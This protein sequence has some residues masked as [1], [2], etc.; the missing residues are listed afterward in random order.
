MIQARSKKQIYKP[1]QREVYIRNSRSFN[2]DVHEDRHQRFYTKY[3]IY[4]RRLKLLLPQY[5]YLLMVGLAIIIFFFLIN[6]SLL[7]NKQDDKSQNSLSGS[8]SGVSLSP[9]PTITLIPIPTSGVTASLTP[10][11]TLVP[12]VTISSTTIVPT[13]VVSNTGILS[14]ISNIDKHVFFPV[15]KTTAIDSNFIPEN[16]TN[17]ASNGIP[18]SSGGFMIK[19]IVV[20]DLKDL[21]NAASSQGINLRV[22][23]AYRSYNEQ[24]NTFNYWVDS[25]LQRGKTQAEAEASAN[26]YSAKAGFSEH[27]LGTTMDINS[28][29]ESNASSLDYTAANT[30]AWDWLES[31][32]EKYGFVLSYP[33][34]KED[35]TGYVYEPWHIRWVGKDVAKELVN[36]DYKNPSNSVTST[37]YFREIWEKV[38]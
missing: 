37:G 19:S 17:L 3:R 21:F 32:L 18:V 9:T 10:T 8:I 13:T 20:S 12:T 23:S 26:T 36:K 7:K 22:A 33:D 16:L 35:K 28:L 27:Q 6:S 24:V 25:E 1:Q 15:D 34:G 5:K 14:K 38:R 31:N 4:K 30:K 2:I 29:N 11:R